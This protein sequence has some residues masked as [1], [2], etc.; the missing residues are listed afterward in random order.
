VF[1]STRDAIPSGKRYSGRGF[2]F[3]QDIEDDN[4]KRSSN[5][6]KKYLRMKKTKVN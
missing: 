2:T 3:V 4:P 5:L 6:C 1:D